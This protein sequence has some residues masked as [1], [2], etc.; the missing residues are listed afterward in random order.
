MADKRLNI[1][2]STTGAKKAKSELGGVSGGLKSLGKQAIMAGGAFFA[3]RGIISGMRSVVNAAAEQELAEKKL[4]AVLKSTGYAAGLQ[5]TELK[6]LA[7]QLQKN[8]MFGDEAI[9]GAESLMLTFTKVGKDVFPDAIETVLN[10]STAM[11]TDLQ[12]SVV[13]LGKALNDPI[14]GISALSRVG[15]QLTEDQKDQIKS[16]TEVGDIASAQKVILGEL[17]T[18]FGGLAEAAGDTMAGSMQQAS[19]AMGDAGE[20]IGSLLAPAVTNIAEWFGEAAVSV[21]D[22]FGGLTQTPLEKTIKELQDLGASTEALMSLQKIQLERNLIKFN[23]ELKN[24]K[25]FYTDINDLQ[26]LITKNG[27]ETLKNVDLMANG[28]AMI[29]KSQEDGIEL[30]KERTALVRRSNKEEGEAKA[31]TF[32]MIDAYHELIAQHDEREED[33]ISDIEHAERMVIKLGEESVVHE[34]NLNILINIK[35]S[36]AEILALKGMQT[37]ESDRQSIFMESLGKHAKLS[38]EELIGYVKTSEEWAKN[39]SSLAEAAGFKSVYEALGMPEPEEIETLD[40]KFK[41]FIA[42]KREEAAATE[43]QIKLTAM[44][45]AEDKALAKQLG[46]VK[47]E[48]DESSYSMQTFKDNLDQATAASIQQAS[49][50]KSTSNALKASGEAAKNVAIVFITA[51]IQKAVATWI[52]EYMKKSKLHPVISGVLAL[53]GGAAFGSLMAS[54]LERNFAEGGIVPG[55][56]NRDT[57]PAMLTPGEVILNQAQQ[58][59]LVGGMGVTINI[60]GNMV[61]NESF[62]RDTLIPELS[63]AR[64]M[65]LA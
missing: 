15:V 8:T 39:L 65:N 60:Q 44:L 18:Q 22:F 61:G 20:Q 30:R 16:F 17:E 53:A 32:A 34:K 63:K 48:T 54:T 11:G 45:I 3:A 52:T 36:E 37:V 62:V 40:E 21:G 56:G 10:M 57:V 35:K 51:E 2:V 1:K 19:N 64:K 25:D 50:V 7:S 46:L 28:E 33:L 41:N 58:E 59:N 49:S 29:I 23:T 42:T 14:T 47:I 31:L 43:E 24:S 27:E 38:K 26:S 55:Q 9:I 6:N 12:S 4:E 5:A 13:Q